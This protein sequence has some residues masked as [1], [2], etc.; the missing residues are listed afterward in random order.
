MKALDYSPSVP[1]LLVS[2]IS[3]AFP[4][5]AQVLMASRPNIGGGAVTG[6]MRTGWHVCGRGHMWAPHGTTNLPQ[7]DK[8]QLLNTPPGTNTSAHTYTHL[9][10]ARWMMRAAS[11][12]VQHCSLLSSPC[13]RV[14]MDACA[15]EWVFL[16]GLL[17][18]EDELLLN[19]GVWVWSLVAAFSVICSV[20]FLCFCE[21]VWASDLLGALVMWVSLFFWG[22]HSLVIVSV[23]SITGTFVEGVH[24]FEEG[25]SLTL[26]VQGGLGLRLGGWLQLAGERSSFSLVV[27]GTPDTVSPVTWQWQL[28]ASGSSCGSAALLLLEDLLLWTSE[29]NKERKK[30]WK[31]MFN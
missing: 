22:V 8:L 16:E 18:S 9:R 6:E 10:Q 15:V 30:T 4:P 23:W 28:E 20:W 19:E 5:T 24:V 17:W 1:C 26:G 31:R 3:H 2:P 21:E 11:V 13:V 12:L 25:W 27:W 7:P 29:R 14:V